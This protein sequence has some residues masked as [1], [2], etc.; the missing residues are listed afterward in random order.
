VPQTDSQCP[1]VTE[2]VTNDE[3]RSRTGQPLLP[4]T[5][6]SRRLSFFGHLHRTDPSQDHYLAFWVL[7]MIGDGGLAVPDNPG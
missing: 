4:D 7:L 1:L 5:V 2:F 6:R 3:I